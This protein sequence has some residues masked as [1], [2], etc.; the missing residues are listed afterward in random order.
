MGAPQ[1]NACLC[2]F[3]GPQPVLGV[4]QRERLG[5]GQVHGEGGCNSERMEV[6][7]QPGRV[8]RGLVCDTPEPHFRVGPKRKSGAPKL[9][10]QAFVYWSKERRVVGDERPELEVNGKMVIEGQR[11]R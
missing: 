10:G 6:E 5:P 8:Y 2:V 9:R 11:D 1:S 3:E 4:N 7:L